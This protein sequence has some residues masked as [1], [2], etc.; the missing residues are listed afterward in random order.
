MILILQFNA[1]TKLIIVPLLGSLL[2]S[3]SS[4][5]KDVKHT[6]LSFSNLDAK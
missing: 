4:L 1:L 2:R 3:F 6:T 5:G